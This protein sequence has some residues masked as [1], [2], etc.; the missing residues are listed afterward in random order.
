MRPADAQESELII[1]GGGVL[2][3]STFDLL[4]QRHQLEL[5]H[6]E[7]TAC[8]QQLSVIDLIVDREQ[9][10][11]V[12]ASARAF[13]AEGDLDEAAR[14]IDRARKLA[15]TIA[16]ALA[17]SADAYGLAEQQAAR[18]SQSL[19]A[20]LSYGLGL[21]LPGLSVFLVPR[22]LPAALGAAIGF[23]VMPHVP[24][25]QL[26]GWLRENNE[27]LSDPTVVNFMRLAVMSADDFVGGSVHVRPEV[28]RLIGDEGLGILGL[29]TSVGIL[30][31][32]GNRVG[33]LA[34]TPVVVQMTQRRADVASPATFEERAQRLPQGT[35]QIRI[36]RYAVAGAPDSFD[37]YLAGT[38]DFGLFATV[39]PWDMT[40]NLTSL[41]LGDAG[42]YRA[43]EAAMRDA[44]IEKDS[45]VHFTGHSQGGLVA[46]MLA[47]SGDYNTQ[48]LFTM[49]APVGQISVPSDVPWIAIEHTNDLVP[50][51]GGV[52][53][54]PDAIRVRR[55]LFID[56]EVPS[57]ATLPA[58]EL[59]RYR[60]TAALFDARSQH[61]A[62]TVSLSPGMSTLYRAE[63]Q[64]VS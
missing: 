58:H 28:M 23:A 13:V 57:D 37:V 3:V 40:S 45:P 19:A 41:A 36:D 20:Q 27:L 61:A 56:G 63:R 18:F 44:G 42:S 1:S 62:P 43:V 9:L 49:G 32:M 38:K 14:C 47:A 15:S 5:L 48:G 2:A 8:F 17:G 30:I 51:L 21:L 29:A 46:S 55:E 11:A 33:A 26:L 16:L 39:D 6:A 24:R 64:P 12:D 4:V 50:A 34:E 60:E 59:K 25:H 10:Y 35:A 54:N 7:L 53:D 52:W 22:V 31:R